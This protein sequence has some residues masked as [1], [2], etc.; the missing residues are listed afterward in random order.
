[1]GSSLSIGEPTLASVPRLTRRAAV[2]TH[3]RSRNYGEELPRVGEVQR[4]APPTTAALR[5]SRG[6]DLDHTAGCRGDA[7]FGFSTPTMIFSA[8]TTTPRAQHP[9]PPPPQPCPA[10][11]PRYA[12]PYAAPCAGN[13]RTSP[14]L[15][16]NAQS[17]MPSSATSPTAP[18]ASTPSATSTT[19]P[20]RSSPT[21]ASRPR[22]SASSMASGASPRPAS[23]PS[24]PRPAS[25]PSTA[26]SKPPP[27]Q[28]PRTR[29]PAKPRR[30]SSD[31]PPHAGEVSAQRTEGVSHLPPFS[32]RGRRCPR[33]GR[34]RGVIPS[35]APVSN[36]PLP[37]SLSPRGR[38]C[39]RS[40]R[41]RGVPLRGPHLHATTRAQKKRR[42]VKARR[43]PVTWG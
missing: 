29:P 36:R 24:P 13:T 34:M 38:R 31:P 27:I 18:S 6:T 5:V 28:P 30:R 2:N 23:R 4:L 21:S 10:P 35:V 8:H 16:P 12:A 32:P 20:L 1:M 3:A 33:S 37:I 26:S 9:R 15:M 11:P 40:G 7:V 14:T 43:R 42:A 41:M 22:S 39:P 17:L 19:S 25:P